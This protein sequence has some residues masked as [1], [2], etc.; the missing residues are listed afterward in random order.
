MKKPREK[1]VS[2]SVDTWKKIGLIGALLGLKKYQVI[3]KLADDFVEA[4]PAIKNT[5]NNYENTSK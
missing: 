3:E 1:T 4:T 2:A 5:L